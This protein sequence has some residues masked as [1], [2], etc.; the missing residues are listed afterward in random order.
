MLLKNLGVISREW[1]DGY[2]RNSSAEECL[3]RAQWLD[4]AERLQSEKSGH[5][6]SSCRDKSLVLWKLIKE[7]NKYGG[8]RSVSR[9]SFASSSTSSCHRTATTSGSWDMTLRLWDLQ[10]DNTTRRL[11]G[12]HEGVLLV[13]VSADNRQISS[14]ARDKMV[15]PWNTLADCKYTI[16]DDGHSDWVNCLRFSPSTSNPLM[17]APARTKWSRYGIWSTVNWRPTTKATTATSTPSPSL[18]TAPFV[19]PVARTRGDLP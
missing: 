16:Q 14:D 4:H 7:H 1:H 9:A 2:S 10:S 15:K 11:R 12:Q 18:Q 17:S 6:L 19:P 13:M 3:L 5:I 8:R